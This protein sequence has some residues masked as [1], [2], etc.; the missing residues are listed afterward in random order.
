MSDKRLA[1][2]DEAVSLSVEMKAYML[3]QKWMST[4]LAIWQDKEQ[5]ENAAIATVNLAWIVLY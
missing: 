3:A 4:I 1:I 5:E 2:L